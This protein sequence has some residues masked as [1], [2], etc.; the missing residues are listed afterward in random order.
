MKFEVHALKVAKVTMTSNSLKNGEWLKLRASLYN[1]F[2]VM[3][4]KL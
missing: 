4:F 3:A 2:S 1:G